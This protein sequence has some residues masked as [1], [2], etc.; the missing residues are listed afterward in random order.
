MT[1]INKTSALALAALIIGAVATPVLA[2][3]SHNFDSDYYLTRLH[4]DG[5]NAIAADD[6]SG[7]TLRATVRLD[8]G[9]TIFE[10]FDKDTLQKV[11]PRL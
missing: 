8:N 1:T 5:I 2:V 10:F 9:N 4:Y 6:Y 7:D 3:D 11:G